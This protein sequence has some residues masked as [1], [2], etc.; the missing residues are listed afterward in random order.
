MDCFLMEVSIHEAREA[1]K[2]KDMKAYKKAKEQIKNRS[3]H[4]K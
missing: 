4:C 1:R 3:K 2:A